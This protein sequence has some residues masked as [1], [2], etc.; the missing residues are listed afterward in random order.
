MRHA[1][2]LNSLRKGERKTLEQYSAHP[3][4]LNSLLAIAQ[5][6]IAWKSGMERE[7]CN[8]NGSVNQ[9]SLGYQYTIQTTTLIA[10]DIIEQK[11]Y[12]EAVADFAPVLVGRGPWMEEIKQNM[13]YDAAG[14]FEEGIQGLSS[15]TQIGNVEVGMSPVTAK[16][17]SWAKGYMYS[18]PEMQKALASNNWDVVASKYKALTRNWQLGIQKVGFLGRKSDLT[19][20]PG[21]LSNSTVNVNTTFIGGPISSMSAADFD[22]FVAGIIQLYLDN[23]NDTRLPT[24]FVMPRSDFVGLGVLVAVGGVSIAM[25]KLEVLEKLFKGICGQNFKIMCTAYGNK[26]R[27]AGYWATNGT[28]RYALYND[29]RETIHMDIPVDLNICAPATGNNFQ[30]NGVG[31][32]QFTGMIA[33]RVPEVL[34][35]DDAASI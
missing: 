27:N 24:R 26:A 35:L 28:N 34:Y 22:A 18:L 9:S 31:Y 21:L 7:L 4:L 25:T 3:Q 13:T 6:P 8:A 15:R 5:N 30:W 20:F 10:A 16:I 19:N 1:E 2:L 23:S 11:F 32:G 29:D 33:Y 14:P 17:A 12:E